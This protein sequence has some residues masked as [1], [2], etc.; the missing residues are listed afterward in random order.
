M[1]LSLITVNAACF[2]LEF[3]LLIFS[4]QNEVRKWLSIAFEKEVKKWSDDIEPELMDGY[5]FSNFAVDV[6]PVGYELY[7]LCNIIL[8]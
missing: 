1:F 5:Y 8:L 3:M 6:L 4:H 2:S 7:W